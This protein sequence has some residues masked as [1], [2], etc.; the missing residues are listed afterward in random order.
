MAITR[1]PELEQLIQKRKNLI[2]LKKV[3]Q[4][5]DEETTE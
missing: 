3:M 4:L 5:I 1:E 2:A